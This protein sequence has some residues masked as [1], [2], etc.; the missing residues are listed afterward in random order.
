MLDLTPYNLVDGRTP[1]E[2]P[3]RPSCTASHPVIHRHQNLKFYRSKIMNVLIV[4]KKLVIP[5]VSHTEHCL[6]L[7][8]ILFA[9]DAAYC[10][11]IWRSYLKFTVKSW[12]S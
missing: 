5:A 4:V 1:P 11:L 3:C 10:Y 9:R 7:R 2:V 6:A 8:P 12:L